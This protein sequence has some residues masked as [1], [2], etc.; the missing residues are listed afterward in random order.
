MRSLHNVFDA[1][2]ARGDAGDCLG[3]TLIGS[4][5][6]TVL[7]SIALN[8]AGEVYVG[9]ITTATT[10]PG[11]GPLQP[12]PTAGLIMKL[13][14]DLSTLF[15][16][17]REGMQVS[18]VAISETLPT[19]T[20]ANIYTAGTEVHDPAHNSPPRAFFDLLANDLQYVRIRNYWKPDEY[21][22]IESGVPT[23]GPIQPGWY[24]ARW[25]LEQ[26]APFLFWIHNFWKPDEYLNI[27]N[28]LQ[29]TSLSPGWL[30][31]RWVMEPVA[32]SNNNLY[33]IRN[34]WNPNLYLN[35]QNGALAATEVQPGWFSAMW[36]I[37]H[38]Y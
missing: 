22:N 5:G 33:R 36:T 4:N 19:V 26:P 11:N 14:P 6:D 21:L 17:R 25:T 18:G 34:M 31:A 38:V 10:F 32:G 3:A 35:N 7:Q 37:E 8:A 29:S 20:P 16:S 1:M 12:H 15:Y 27:Q 30:S 2:I 24:S 28:G 9:S 13:S 23:S